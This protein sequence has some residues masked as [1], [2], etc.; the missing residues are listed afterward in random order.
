MVTFTIIQTKLRQLYSI[1]SRFQVLL[2]VDVD[3]LQ[4]MDTILC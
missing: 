1:L 3:D 2:N 4:V